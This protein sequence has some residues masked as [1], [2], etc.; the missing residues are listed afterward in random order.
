M[1]KSETNKTVKMYTKVLVML[2]A[3]SLMPMVLSRTRRYSKMQS[4]TLYKIRCDLKCFDVS[5]EAKSLV[6]EN[7]FP[8]YD[9]FC[10]LFWV[11]LKV[12]FDNFGENNKVLT[13]CSYGINSLQE[14]KQHTIRS[15][16]KE[17][18]TLSD[19]FHRCK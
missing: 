3:V 5:K 13:I 14:K 17:R 16:P 18:L 6:S 12:G 4:N 1:I 9:Y 15:K 7:V 11:L 2:M 8:N 10:K 19:F